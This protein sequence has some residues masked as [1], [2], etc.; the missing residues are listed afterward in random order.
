MY[1]ASRGI[2]NQSTNQLNQIKTQENVSSFMSTASSMAAKR[3]RTDDEDYD[4]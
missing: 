1:Q 2:Y 3:Q 4:I